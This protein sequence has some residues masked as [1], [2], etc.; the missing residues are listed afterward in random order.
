LQA[1]AWLELAAEER[2]DEAKLILADQHT[3]LSAEEIS[4]VKKL[5][6]QLLQ[7]Q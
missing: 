3:P 5:K 6:S 1:I 4:R 7:H 2:N